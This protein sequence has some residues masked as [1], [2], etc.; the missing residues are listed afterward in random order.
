MQVVRQ[1]G[2][3]RNI[4]ISLEIVLLLHNFLTAFFIKEFLKV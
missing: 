4:F 1:G 3:A 2:F